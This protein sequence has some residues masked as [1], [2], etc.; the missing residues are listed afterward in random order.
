[1]HTVKSWCDACAESFERTGY[2]ENGHPMCTKPNVPEGH[3]L[4][5][6]REL[7]EA[8]W[9]EDVEAVEQRR[10]S[11]G[12]GIF[13]RQR[14]TPTARSIARPLPAG[15]LCCVE[16]TA[17][18]TLGT[19]ILPLAAL[20]CAPTPCPAYVP[21]AVASLVCDGLSC[22]SNADCPDPAKPICRGGYCQ[23]ER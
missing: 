10:R 3:R 19:L 6:D 18:R 4:T 20:G 5:G 9:R 16:E 11:G 14:L 23:A 2:G 7:T 15:G 22:E 12:S 13:V 8:G 17:M 1:M 21:D